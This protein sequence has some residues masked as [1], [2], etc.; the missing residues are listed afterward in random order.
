MTH[1]ARSRTPGPPAELTETPRARTPRRR[2]LARCRGSTE[3]SLVFPDGQRKPNRSASIG[4]N[5]IHARSG[6]AISRGTPFLP[7]TSTNGSAY[8]GPGLGA[9]RPDFSFPQKSGELMLKEY[10]KLFQDFTKTALS[11]SR[12]CR[13]LQ[14]KI[15][16]KCQMLEM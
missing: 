11:V 13:Y 5:A 3:I 8:V 15:V 14:R 12:I 1:R 4:S 10:L 9:T 6:R 16:R 7:P 2:A